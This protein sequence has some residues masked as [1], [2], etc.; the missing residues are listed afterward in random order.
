M[1]PEECRLCKR[2]H[3]QSCPVIKGALCSVCNKYGHFYEECPNST[4]IFHR[5]AQFLEQLIPYSVRS[6]YGIE[7]MTPF[8][9]EENETQYEYISDVKG[10]LEERGIPIGKSQEECKRRLERWGID[11][12]KIIVYKKNARVK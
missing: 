10:A 4:A 11:N 6:Y 9:K 1:E 8:R 12:R 5:E 7:T 2:M 3:I